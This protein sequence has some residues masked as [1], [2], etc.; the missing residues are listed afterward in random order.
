MGH[1]L[2]TTRT[3]S[4]QKA[5]TDRRGPATSGPAEAGATPVAAPVPAAP[6]PADPVSPVAAAPAATPASSAAPSPAR[7]EIPA[8]PV[9]TGAP[10]AAPGDMDEMRQEIL[11]L[12][13]E[14]RLLR[15]ANAELE[16]VA[17]RD[18]LTPL[19]NRRHFLT[20]L[21][22]RLT[23]AQ[24]YN[25][26]AAVLF[27]DVNRLK[28][29]NDVYGHGAGDYALV[30]VA[31][32]I[33]THI[34]TSDVAARLGGDEFAIILEEVDEEQALAKADDLDAVLRSTRC[35]YGEAELPVSAS[36]GFTML[37]PDDSEEALIERA[38]ANMYARKRAWH[39]ESGPVDD[40]DAGR[41]RRPN[42]GSAA[43]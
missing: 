17:I 35:L 33:E 10:A 14:L 8:P 43:A 15:I 40:S 11:A 9:S 12:R 36:I 32:L 27:I 23:R 21:H 3:P 30:H 41:S 13:R 7:T 34:R 6:V 20:A 31:Q 18:T 38:D 4:G 16:R 28:Y 2:T 1:R 19:F 39:D 25:S 22:E 26:R 42:R 24:R 37:Q 29:I 5:E